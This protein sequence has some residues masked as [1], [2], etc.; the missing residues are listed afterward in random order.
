V[1][2]GIAVIGWFIV[3][4]ALTVRPS[5]ALRHFEP[6]GNIPP[7]VS[8]APE[9]PLNRGPVLT[10]RS[11]I[12]CARLLRF[13]ALIVGL[14]A[15]FAFVLADSAH[16]LSL[17]DSEF[18]ACA[19]TRRGEVQRHVIE[20]A[21]AAS[22]GGE[23]VADRYSAARGSLTGS[24]TY[25]PSHTS[26]TSRDLVATKPGT[27]S[28][29]CRTNSFVPET[30]VLMGDG[31]T[32]PISQVE[33]GDKVVA[34]DPESGERGIR[35]VT[36]TIVGDGIK[37][38]VGIRIRTSTGE[39]T[40]WA[41]EHHPFWDPSE[42]EWVDAEELALGSVLLTDDGYRVTVTGITEVAR[43]Q[44]VHNLTVEGIHTYYVVA[45]DEAVL[46]HNCLEGSDL[47]LL[48][49]RGGKTTTDFEDVATRL[50]TNNGI[51]R[52]VA[53]K[54][55]HAIKGGVENNRDVVFTRSGGV[56]DATSGD[57]LG[58]LTSG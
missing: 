22:S 42:E 51:S 9:V 34:F 24:C 15:V 29:A 4:I 49:K 43:V 13:P 47:D 52:E 37:Q 54:R 30:R 31:T 36:D 23:R 7:F 17:G 18:R 21:T 6:R 48:I 57:Y 11:V 3:L 50:S 27:V 5:G 56:Y 35:T 20:D 33:V 32:K 25:D 10:R 40:I 45:A 16:A 28:A 19:S 2:V 39:S 14:S 26:R 1:S 12:G 46:V 58:S 53:S 55:L 8:T 41:T 44:R 38:L